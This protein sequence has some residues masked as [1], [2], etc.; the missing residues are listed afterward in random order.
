M[1]CKKCGSI[2][3][4]QFRHIGSK[5]WCCECGFVIKEEGVGVM[6]KE[7]KIDSLSALQDFVDGLPNG[8]IKNRKYR[9]VDAMGKDSVY[10]FEWE[11]EP[12]L[13]DDDTWFTS[14]GDN[15]EITP[16]NMPTIDFDVDYSECIFEVG[17]E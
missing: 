11:I 16:D 1:K 4:A 8:S 9:T 2:K 17:D 13:Q 10:I 6:D 15:Y 12:E 5:V 7:I 3:T 14:F